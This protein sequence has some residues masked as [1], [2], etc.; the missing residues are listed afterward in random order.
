MLR[1]A[2][3]GGIATG[4]S[5]CLARFARKGVPTI[6]AD[7]LA[8]T[9]VARGEPAWAAIRERFGDGVLQSNGEL[10]RVRLGSVVFKD[11][12]ARADLEAIVHPAVYRAIRAWFEGLP[13]QPPHFAIAD[14]PLLF[15]TRREQDFDRVLVTWCPEEMQVA[16]LEARNGMSEEEARQ[17]IA[18]QLPADEKR[19]RA[20]HVIRTDGSFADTDAQIEAIIAALRATPAANS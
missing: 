6:D 15:E 1:V 10:D 8:R 13:D 12:A 17:R 19:R 9:V 16:R 7:L 11:A 14:I 5:Y 18:A 3:T 20:D 4:K 2:L